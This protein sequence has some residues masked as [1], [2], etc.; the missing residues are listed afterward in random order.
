MW[1][2][3]LFLDPPTVTIQ[4]SSYSVTTGNS[5]TLV[6]TVTSNL[7]ITS[8]QWQRNVGGTITTI[9]SNTNTNK[10]SGSTSSTPSLTIFSTTQSD[11]GTYTCFASN[12]VGTGQSSTTQLSITESMSIFKTISVTNDNFVFL[13]IFV[14]CF[15]NMINISCYNM[16]CSSKHTTEPD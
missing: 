8:V 13:S 16:I 6:C 7:P 3:D 15:L 1:H 4:Q 11:A 5:V 9:N 10:Y 14:S 12:N 2:D